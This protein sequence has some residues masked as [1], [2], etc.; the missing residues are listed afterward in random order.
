MT[1]AVRNSRESFSHAGGNLHPSAKIYPT[2]YP[3][4]SAAAFWSRSSSFL[5]CYKSSAKSKK[6]KQNFRKNRNGP[7]KKTRERCSKQI[8]NGWWA[9]RSLIQHF[10]D[11]VELFSAHFLLEFLLVWFT[12][13]IQ[14]RM[15]WHH[16]HGALSC[17]VF[18]PLDPSSIRS[19]RIRRIRT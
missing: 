10:L 1:T 12:Q 3:F 11:G 14:R 13:S 4:W 16:R 9:S 6:T 18:S 7:N 15:G 17:F 8:Q 5:F 2:R 19:A